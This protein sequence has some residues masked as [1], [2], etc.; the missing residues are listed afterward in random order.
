MYRLDSP[1]NYFIHKSSSSK[2]INK[3]KNKDTFLN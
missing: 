3:L 1:D 2:F